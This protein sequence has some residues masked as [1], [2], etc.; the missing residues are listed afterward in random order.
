[1]P[2]KIND[3][4]PAYSILENENIFIMTD[5]RALSQDI[6][7][8]KIAIL[9]LMPTKIITETQLMRLLS[10]SPL[11]LEITLV[12]TS[13]YTPKNTPAEHLSSFYKDFNEIRNEKFDG[14]IITGAPLEDKDF[15]DVSYWKEF[16]AILDWAKK[17]V[18][19]C[20]YICWGALAGLYYHYGIPKVAFKEKLSGVFEQKTL[21]P[22]HPLLRGFNEVFLA[23]HSRF[24]GID[25]EA[26]K[27][28]PDVDILCESEKAGVCI[29]ASHDMRHIFVTG[30]PEYDVDTLAN[31]YFRDIAKGMD[32][33]VPENYFPQDDPK[34]P[35]SNRWKAHAN[36]LYANWLN[37]FVYQR[38]PFDITQI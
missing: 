30:H 36:L 13:T 11:Q 38:T 2:I 3:S 18:Y 7:P 17:N 4:L 25:K 5:K 37:Y 19:S 24:S 20:F 34:N 14:L 32:I 33:A 6:R 12:I 26:L 29:A 22:N 21:L 35:P 15:Q 10:N 31:E 1:M 8:L 16:C 28:C 27:K 9:N 23:P